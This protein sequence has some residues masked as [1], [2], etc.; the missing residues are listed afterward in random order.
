MMTTKDVESTIFAGL[1]GCPLSELK[2]MKDQLA[3]YKRAVIQEYIQSLPI[4]KPIPIERQQ[5]A[6]VK[7]DQT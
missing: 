3:I 2:W 5:S 1:L 4:A 7:D 6:K